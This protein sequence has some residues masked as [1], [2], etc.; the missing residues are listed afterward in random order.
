MGRCLDVALTLA[1][2]SLR[3]PTGY[4]CRFYV[5]ANYPSWQF[6]LLRVLFF[7]R[8][9]FI[10]ERR[11]DKKGMVNAYNH[12]FER[13]VDDGCE[14]VALWADDL[15]PE[16]RDWLMILFPFLTA[17]QFKFGIFSSDEGGHKRSFGWNVFSGVPCAHFY[18][19]KADA[20]PGHLLNPRLK[21]YVG[22]NEICASLLKRQIEIDLLPVRVIHQ[23]TFNATR[24]G[25]VPHVAADLNTVYELHP[26]LRG[27]L[28]PIVLRGDLD[29]PICRFVPDED[30]LRRFGVD[31]EPLPIDAFTDRARRSE[32]G[33]TIS[34]IGRVRRAWNIPFPG[35][36]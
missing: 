22:D 21:A 36:D 17:K 30:H 20:L 3:T 19:A 33:W 13:A 18:V 25:N 23:P 7:S 34:A 24:S 10:D 8:A 12:A 32:A 27:R 29:N 2:T 14:W 15:L 6:L 4:R 16:R 1:F 11:L 28:D 31:A 26:D 35:H 5:C 9:S